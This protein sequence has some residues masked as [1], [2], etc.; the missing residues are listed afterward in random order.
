[1]K[2]HGLAAT[3]GDETEVPDA[4][5]GAWELEFHNNPDGRDGGPDK[6]GCASRPAQPDSS[7]NDP[8]I[9]F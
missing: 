8:A 6:F 5:F 4:R 7:G 3:E 2:R 9:R 1:M